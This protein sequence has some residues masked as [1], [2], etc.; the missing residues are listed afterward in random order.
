VG[1]SERGI[2]EKGISALAVAAAAAP[3]VGV[4]GLSS[5][6]SPHFFSPRVIAE[7]RGSS[8]NILAKSMLMVMET[9]VLC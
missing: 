1:N 7:K 3:P 2:S 5:K 9:I 6:R 8:E 4:V